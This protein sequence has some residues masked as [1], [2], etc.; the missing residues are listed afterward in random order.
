MFSQEDIN[1]INNASLM[2]MVEVKEVVNLDE[3]LTILGRLSLRWVTVGGYV[4][5]MNSQVDATI[6]GEPYLALQLWFNVKSGKII[7][8]IW[9]QTVAVEEVSNGL[10]FR[11]ACMSHFRVFST[12]GKVHRIYGKH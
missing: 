10:E 3:A 4:V 9:D 7:R 8:R 12:A 11:E 2:N 6:G 5:I 1:K